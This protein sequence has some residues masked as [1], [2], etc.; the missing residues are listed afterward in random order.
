VRP[1]GVYQK[2]CSQGSCI[3]GRA[4]SG[5]HLE[6]FYRKVGRGPPRLCPTGMNI[7]RHEHARRAI[8]S[9]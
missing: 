5:W 8:F 2:A 3:R 7:G 4:L 6:G 1:A 9:A